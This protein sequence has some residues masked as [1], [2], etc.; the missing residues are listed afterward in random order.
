MDWMTAITVLACGTPAPNW[1]MRHMQKQATTITATTYRASL[2]DLF[3]GNKPPRIAAAGKALDDGLLYFPIDLPSMSWPA[4]T[5]RFTNRG[6]WAA[7]RPHQ[8]SGMLAQAAAAEGLA[9]PRA[10]PAACNFSIHWQRT[11]THPS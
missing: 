7:E 3:C 5:A 8:P 4:H 9:F 2:R 10:R 1:H 6:V 11:H